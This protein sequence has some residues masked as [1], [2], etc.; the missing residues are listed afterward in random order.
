M[1]DRL[2]WFKRLALDLPQQLR[3][4]YCLFRDPRVPLPPKVGVA[5]VLGLVAVPLVDLPEALPVIGELDALALTL[6][7]LR[8]F[9]ALCPSDVVMEQ[10]Q[11]ITERRSR[12]D[13]DV[14][15]GERLALAIAGR[16]RR[17]AP[18]TDLQAR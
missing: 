15:A 6:L 9:V 2:R 18:G 5:A 11:L 7:A 16:F 14:M 4:A 13:D 1:L 10:K 12:F 17:G 3:L 8:L